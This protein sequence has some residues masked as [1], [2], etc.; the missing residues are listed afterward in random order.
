MALERWIPSPRAR[1]WLYRAAVKLLIRPRVRR[2]GIPIVS[3]TGTNGKSSV[4]KLLEGIYREAGRRVGC[5]HTDGVSF[6]GR[7][8][9]RGDNAGPNGLWRILRAGRPDVMVAE[10]ARGG[11]LRH[12][13][14]FAR[15]EVAV[16]TNI[17]E[18]HLGE[19]GVRSLDDLASVKSR[20]VR[21]AESAVLNANDPRV[22]AMASRCRGP[23]YYF[24]A[25]DR[26]DRANL[27][28]RR[29]GAL[30]SRV[31]GVE[32]RWVAVEEMPFAW[33]GVLDY[34]IENAL[35]ALATVAA[36]RHRVSADPDA[37][38]RALRSFG[39][40]PRDHIGRAT[41]L[42][43]KEDWILLLEC[44]NPEGMRRIE[45]VLE[46]IR[47]RHDIRRV[48]GLLTDVGGEQ[49]ERYRAMS[50]WAARLCDRVSVSSP[51]PFYYRTH[52][53][54]SLV[55]MLSSE[56]PDDKRSESGGSLD[57]IRERERDVSGKTL[58]VLFNCLDDPRVVV[59]ALLDR[60][61]RMPQP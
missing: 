7:M 18:D 60:A 40:D 47:R 54:E 33:G 23:V 19:H 37:V 59:E 5:S 12:G 27:C 9:R 56:I 49:P 15:C 51:H 17:H 38:R 8:I 57:D 34:Q 36:M 13:I 41:L 3:V 44:K 29:D 39:N 10:T 58:F 20:I 28:F 25:E 21:L 43:E 31:D 1:N 6:D 14:G 4:C 22:C 52:T 16:V 42:R 61:E 11:I 45:P 26:K 2:A 53:D 55:R 35:A 50:C 32:T 30:W 24:S 46:W 48:V